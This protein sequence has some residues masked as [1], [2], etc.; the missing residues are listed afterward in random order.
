MD[1]PGK[2]DI[3]RGESSL[4]EQCS[5]SCTEWSSR[6]MTQHCV[7]SSRTDLHSSATRRSRPMPIP[8]DLRAL[9][10]DPE[11]REI[12]QPN[13]VSIVLEAG[14]SKGWFIS[15]VLLRPKPTTMGLASIALPIRIFFQFFISD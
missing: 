14:M 4:A 8:I 13:S 6:L 5:K 3:F 7:T 9:A 15:L 11:F 2:P 1:V 10:V 12:T